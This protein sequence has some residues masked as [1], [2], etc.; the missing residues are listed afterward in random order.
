MRR[1][2]PLDLTGATGWV[3]A[4]EMSGAT[5]L[6]VSDL[7]SGTRYALRV[8]GCAN[9]APGPWSGPVQQLAP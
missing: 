6:N 7:T 5:L 8:R 4:P 9:S 3:S 1:S 2:T